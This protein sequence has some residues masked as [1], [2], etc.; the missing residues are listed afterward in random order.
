MGVGARPAPLP[1]EAVPSPGLEVDY[2]VGPQSN[3][4]ASRIKIEY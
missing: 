2:F 4:D 1:P 3:M